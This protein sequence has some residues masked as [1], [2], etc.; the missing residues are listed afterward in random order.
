MTTVFLFELPPTSRRVPL[1]TGRRRRFTIAAIRSEL[2]GR[3]RDNKP[4]AHVWP[5]IAGNRFLRSSDAEVGVLVFDSRRGEH[6]AA[7]PVHDGNEVEES[8]SRWCSYGG[9][10]PSFSTETKA[11]MS[12]PSVS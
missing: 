7:C 2:V 6:L 3:E 5:A 11:A 1:H 10:T 4:V 12:V 9:F 8:S